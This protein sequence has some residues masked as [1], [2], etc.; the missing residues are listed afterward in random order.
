MNESETTLVKMKTRGDEKK[1][2][3]YRTEKHE[4]ENIL[5]PL[6]LDNEYY[7]KKYKNVKKKKVFL[8][9]TKI[10]LGSASTISSSTMSLINPGA[11]IFYS[12]SKVC[13][14]VLLS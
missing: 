13:Q 9:I 1:N 10:L 7:K 3:K 4:L 14:L 5:K 2:Q 8:I 11:G 12:S 6:K